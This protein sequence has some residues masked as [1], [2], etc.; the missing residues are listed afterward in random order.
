MGNRDFE[1]ELKLKADYQSAQKAAEDTKEGIDSIVTATERANQALDA[2]ASQ[3][4]NRLREMVQRSLAQMD[5]VES[6]V[7]PSSESVSSSGDHATLQARRA[8]VAASQALQHSVAAEMSLIG[9]LETRL[10]RGAISM[11]ELADTEQRL[12]QAMRRDLISTEDYDAALV[13]LNTEQ[14]R[15]EKSAAAA[16]A[17]QQ[18][19]QAA[20][21]RVAD[22]EAASLDRTVGAYDKVSAGMRKI[23]TDEAR[24]TQAFQSG[25]VSG[26]DYVR[27]LSGITNARTKLQGLQDGVTQSANAMK[28]LNFQA[29]QSQRSLAELLQYAATGRWN[30]V[31]REVLLLGR[32]TGAMGMLFSSTGLAIG[33]AVAAVAAF[34]AAAVAGYLQMRAFEGAIIATGDAAGVT[35]GQ[36]GDMRNNIGKSTG[37]YGEAQAALAAFV[38]SGQMAGDSLEQASRAAVNLSTL[39]GES[40][41]QT[42]TKILE[43]AKSPTATLV[44]LNQRYHFLTEAVYLQVRAL[45]AQGRTQDALKIGLQALDEETAHRVTTMKA[46]AG[47]LARAWES[48][49]HAVS[50][51]IQSMKDIGRTD[52]NAQLANAQITLD[53]MR[54]PISQERG[55]STPMQIEQQKKIVEGLKQ[56]IAASEALAKA[57]GARRK[58]Q[59]DLIN[60]DQ[61]IKDDAEKAKKD[62]DEKLAKSDKLIARQQR[63]NKLIEDYNVIAAADPNDKRLYDGSYEK[64]KKEIIKETTE[65][66]KHVAKGPK[67]E[68]EKEQDAAQH[69]LENLKKM[70]ALEDSL[71]DGKKK[72]AEQA[73]I[74]FEVTQG[75]YRL[76]DE[77][78]KQQL[79]DQ[80]K[81]AD[82]ATAR[83]EADRKLIEVRERILGVQDGREDAAL[84]KAR[85]ELELL[86]ADLQK[87][88]R[89]ADAAD[90]SKL[91]G[92]D[93]A[94]TD[95]KNLRKTYEQV[96]GEISIEVQRIQV[97]QQAGF[98]TEVDAQQKIINLYRSK[99]GVLK[100]MVPQ[101][102]A[103]ALTLGGDVG[104][105]ALNN[106]EQ[107]EVKLREMETTTNAM[108]QAFGTT[109]Q[110]SLNSTLD[111]L[112][113]GTAT[114]GDAVRGFFASLLQGMAQFAAQNVAQKA[115]NWVKGLMRGDKTGA[116]DS[117]ATAPAAI[118]TAGT[119]VA[120]AIVNAGD[121]VAAAIRG[122]SVGAGGVGAPA[123][124]QA[125]T[126][127]PAS[128]SVVV[129][130]T[131]AA[132][133]MQDA[134]T[135][136]SAG[137]AAIGQS[138][139]QLASAAGG[140]S[141]GAASV[142]SA[143][144]Q[145]WQAAQTLLVANSASVASGFADGG[146]TGAG[147]KYT[148]AGVVH[149][150]EFVH[151]QEV[152]RQP[153]ALPFLWDFNRRGMAAL[154]HWAG[155]ADGGHV[156]S[157]LYAWA[158][159][160]DSRRFSPEANLR[161]SNDDAIKRGAETSRGALNQRIRLVVV[162]DPNRIPAALKSE[163]GEESFL[164]HAGRNVGQ[165][166]QL[167]DV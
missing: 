28:G 69:E 101:M 62:I 149:A 22:A 78:I 128:T 74:E 58:A 114:L 81:L 79:R 106:V 77:S 145:L 159:S 44:E 70:V 64:I 26:E 52:L 80:A 90:V 13:K 73:R 104:K 48:V 43:L 37:E 57:D 157:T 29:A 46:Q 154:Q 82:V 49:S 138:A 107:I 72:A 11:Q 47:L 116:G 126:P 61:K 34:G 21:Q 97:E 125:D 75:A 39:T 108:Q 19:Q 139:V 121:T 40:I 163:V 59:T 165:L 36:L 6:A 1:I 10:H 2:G 53:N 16:A 117:D 45:E 17:Q 153:G 161:A 41:E 95:L 24:I 27:A 31:E 54:N 105:A 33:G 156:G 51:A 38:N 111:S 150:G 151:R 115:S 18:R 88:G 55:Y 130:G 93:Q 8:N 92:L 162:D 112:I 84:A 135:S 67:S 134:G 32:T 7:A 103:A 5:H 50:S 85:H 137:A 155:Y 132:N 129:N 99:L 35:A 152:V 15:L 14:A 42:T 65:K 23:A 144:L 91:L 142:V 118:T 12:D 131:S 147:G 166:K 63:L 148:P 94:Q 9:E 96:M 83:A 158:N 98:L 66:A 76:A 124:G 122:A 68:E 30:M 100:A 113:K 102:R 167:L 141:P 119:T 20:R 143:A 136:V 86:Q 146:F 110:Q 71:T 133:A 56:Q 25:K 87:Q 120:T 164:Y 109:F 4:S 60:D 140:L 127:A 160:A 123:A 3:Q 89:F